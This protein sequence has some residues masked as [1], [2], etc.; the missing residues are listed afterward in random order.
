MNDS[1]DLLSSVYNKDAELSYFD[2]CFDVVTKIGE[3]SFGEVFKV[4]SKENGILYAVKKS[5]Q[6]FRSEEYRK[7][8][9]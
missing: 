8:N 2:Q 9:G 4:R 1:D 3:G 7:V 6:I 5:K